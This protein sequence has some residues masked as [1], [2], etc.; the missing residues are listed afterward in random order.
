MKTTLI[1]LSVLAFNCSILGQNEIGYKFNYEI[2]IETAQLNNDE[3]K[4]IVRNFIDYIFE[5]QQEKFN[6]QTRYNENG[7]FYISA[8]KRIDQC[9]V[10]DYFSNKE[11]NVLSFSETN[12]K[13]R[14]YNTNQFAQKN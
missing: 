13:T 2:N 5:E 3:P 6:L 14:K 8:N 1:I 4:N 12:E 7:V 11:T 9:V 10:E